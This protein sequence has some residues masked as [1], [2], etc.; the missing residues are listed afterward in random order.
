MLVD[1][2][3]TGSYT[4]ITQQLLRKRMYSRDFNRLVLYKQAPKLKL[5]EIEIIEFGKGMNDATVTNVIR[6]T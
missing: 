5:T 4:A 6:H 1:V 2:L 3:A